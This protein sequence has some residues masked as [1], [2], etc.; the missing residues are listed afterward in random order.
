MLNAHSTNSNNK[1]LKN[2]N[3]SP[4]PQNFNST[5]ANFASVRESHDSI[6]GISATTRGLISRPSNQKY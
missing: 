1:F 6:S 2:E 5:H 3:S 4:H